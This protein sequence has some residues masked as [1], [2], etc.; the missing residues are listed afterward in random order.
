MQWKYDFSLSFQQ[1]NCFHGYGFIEIHLAMSYSNEKSYM[2]LILS[3]YRGTFAAAEKLWRERY[4]DWTP[5]SRN[6]SSRLANWIRT[7]GVVQPQ[8]NRGK[9]IR[10]PITD[11]RAAKILASAELNPDDSLRCRERDS[12]VSHDIICRILRENK[13]HPYNMSL[14]QALN[15]GDFRQRLAFCNWIRQQPPDFHLKILFSD[16]CTSKSDGSV[17]I[18]NCRYWS[19]VNPHWLREMD[20]QHVWKIN[21]SYGI[22]GSRIVGFIFFQESLNSNRYL[23]LI[24][25]DLPVLLENLP[26]QLC[27]NMWLQQNGYSPHTLRVARAV[28]NIMFSN[29]WIAKYPM[30]ISNVRSIIYPDHWTSLSLIIIYGKG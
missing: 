8:H 16:G 9:Q 20:R 4:P 21:V 3:E 27:L 15:Y 10:H 14:H 11:E 5:H 22:I 17:N 6:V 18:W 30:S 29:K 28:L 26:L 23:A 13:F 24:E 7:E 25:T 1:L 2:L 12:G 19:W